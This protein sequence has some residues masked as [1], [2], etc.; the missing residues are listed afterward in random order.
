MDASG[1]AK[2]DGGLGYDLLRLDYSSSTAD[3]RFAFSTDP[4]R[5][6][7][8]FGQGSSFKNFEEFVITT[9]AGNDRITCSGRATT[10]DGN[11][12]I[13]GAIY[14][15]AGAGD[16][17][18]YASEETTDVEGGLGIDTLDLSDFTGKASVRLNMS[19]FNI[20][21]FSVEKVIGT[22]FDDYLEGGDYLDGGLGDDELVGDVGNDRHHGSAGNDALSGLKGNDILDGGAGDDNMYGGAGDD[23]LLGGDGADHLFSSEGEDVLLGGAGMDYLG[24]LSGNDRLEGGSAADTL[25]GGD[26]ADTIVGGERQ[27]V[28]TGGTGSDQFQFFSGDI[29]PASAQADV[30]TDFR[31]GAGD[32]INLRGIDANTSTAD[33]DDRFSF[34]GTG[35]FTGTAGELRYAVV[36]GN[37]FVQGDTN[38]D[39]LADFYIRVDD[40]S[41]LVTA[42][43][44]L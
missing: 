34:L 10:G 25:L 14:A 21:V 27:D 42:D 30:I 8:F 9:G 13:R 37:I 24:G 22:E 41:K 23:R 26:G 4:T 3:L 15:Y 7:T 44:V 2:V 31:H 11:D 35:A 1:F 17:L 16:D 18:I 5:Y 40:V 39:S 43:F 12:I 36:D 38:G 28:L 29:E 33:V 6:S 32:R 19:G 20:E